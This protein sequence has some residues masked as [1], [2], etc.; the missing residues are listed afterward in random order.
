VFVNSFHEV[1][2]IQPPVGQLSRSCAI[3]IRPNIKDGVT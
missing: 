1:S 3:D 2:G